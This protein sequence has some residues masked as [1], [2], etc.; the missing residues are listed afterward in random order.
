MNIRID[1]QKPARLPFQ[2]GKELI[3]VLSKAGYSEVRQRG[4]HIH[5]SCPG[6]IR[7]GT[8]LWKPLTDRSQ[9]KPCGIA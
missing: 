2:S 3:R 7:H 5:L 9:G 6:K 8:R 4:S 1:K